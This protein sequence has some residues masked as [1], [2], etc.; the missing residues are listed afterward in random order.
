MLHCFS[1]HCII[2]STTRRAVRTIQR[3]KALCSIKK[4]FPKHQ[5]HIKGFYEKPHR[6]RKKIYSNAAQSIKN[7]INHSCKA[8]Y[9]ESIY[10]IIYSAQN[11]IDLLIAIADL[12]SR[13]TAK[14]MRSELQKQF[15]ERR[16]K[17]DIKQIKVKAKK[18]ATCIKVYATKSNNPIIAK[19]E[20]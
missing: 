14:I 11:F 12:C 13:F 8:H 19:V 18:L 7:M 1:I 10:L 20:E 5:T 9:K 2:P 15:T 16:I 4:R 6:F 17:N 3:R